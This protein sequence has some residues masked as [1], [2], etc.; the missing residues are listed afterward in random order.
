MRKDVAGVAALAAAA[1]LLRA[2]SLGAP[3]SDDEGGFLV[4]AAQWRPGTSLYGDYWVDRPP[5]LIAAFGVADRLGGATAL[6]VLGGLAVVAAVLLAARVG[7]L[8]APRAPH[9][10]VLA[11]AVAAIFLST[12]L[13]SAGLVKGE[14]L[15]VPPVLLGIVAVLSGMQAPSAAGAARW[16]LL[17]GAAGAVAVGLKQS[18]VEVFLAVA[19]AALVLVRHGRWRRAGLLAACA[20]AAG[21]AVTAASVA[22]AAERGTDPVALWHAVVTFRAD[23]SAVIAEA[24]PAANDGRAAGLVLAFAGSGALGLM[25]AFGRGRRTAG[26]DAG[27]PPGFRAITLAV[28]AWEL[29]AVVLGGSYWLHYLV[30]T[31]PGLVLSAAVAAR[32]RARLRFLAGVVAY[33][34][35]ATVLANVATAVPPG[36]TWSSPEEEV[37]VASYLREVARPGDT[38]VVA[39]GS[40]WILREAGLESPYPLLW[41][42]PVRVR[43]PRLVRFESLLRSSDRPTWVVVEGDSVDSWGLE[44]AGA[45]GVLRRRYRLAHVVG[46]WHLYRAEM[47]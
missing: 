45:D 4:V 38:G 41:S 37:A 27:S 32:E 39:F 1:L 5:L 33:G 26:P 36:P 34:A 23:A 18:T 44:P 43:D 40:P 24:A 46:D 11:A 7:R 29:V 9:A 12:P 42:L 6:R 14:L 17:A 31:V 2:P 22:W 25:L 19:V 15:A 35:A 47:R 8:V 10:P 28:V 30:A 20:G 21:L 3:L 16:W 13:F